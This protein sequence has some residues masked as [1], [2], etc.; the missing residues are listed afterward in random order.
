MLVSATWVMPGW[1]HESRHAWCH[2]C[3]IFTVPDRAATLRVAIRVCEPGSM[4]QLDRAYT[5]SHPRLHA[6]SYSL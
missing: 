5:S 1:W 3:L 6:D 2:T 4:Q